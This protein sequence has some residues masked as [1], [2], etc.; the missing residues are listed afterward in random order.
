MLEQMRAD[1]KKGGKN[2]QEED[3]DMEQEE[4]GAEG[5]GD[6]S[7]PAKP[8]LTKPSHKIGGG[9]KDDTGKDDEWIDEVKCRKAGRSYLGAVETLR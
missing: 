1:S 7:G 2:D 3:E 4:A 5:N 6:G 9:V 8:S